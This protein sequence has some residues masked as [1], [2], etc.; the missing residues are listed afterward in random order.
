MVMIVRNLPRRN[1]IRFRIDRI[2]FLP[3][4]PGSFPHVLHL[5]QDVGDDQ[6]PAGPLGFSEGCLQDYHL[7]VVIACPIHLVAPE[8]LGLLPLAVLV[9]PLLLLLGPGW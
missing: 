8:L 4:V 6:A 1:R 2:R 7:L 9:D 3:G 5:L